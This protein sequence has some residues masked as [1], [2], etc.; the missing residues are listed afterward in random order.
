MKG[1]GGQRQIAPPVYLSDPLLGAADP[2]LFRA[3]SRHPSSKEMPSTRAHSRP[4][5][6]ASVST[7]FSTTCMN[8]ATLLFSSPSA[9]RKKNRSSMSGVNPGSEDVL[10]LKFSLGR[11][12][13]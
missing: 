7:R 3:L 2:G 4:T 10:D 8:G 13:H 6:A 12:H 5:S 9:G 1:A 11:T